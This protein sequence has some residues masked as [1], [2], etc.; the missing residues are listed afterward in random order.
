MGLINQKGDAQVLERRVFLKLLQHVGE[1]LLR[2]DDDRFAIL[3]EARQVVGF[4]GDAHHVFQVGE[5]RDVLPNIRVERF[6]VGEDERNVHQFFV[7]ARVV[8]AVQAVRQPADR[9]RLAA[10]GR[11]VGEILFADVALV[12]E[13]R[14]D[15]L[16][17]FP[18]Q[19]ALMVA[20]EQGEG[21]ALLYITLRL[22]FGHADQEER[23][24]LQQLLLG[25]NFA[26]QKLDRVFVRVPATCWSAPCCASGNSPP[27]AGRWRPSRR[28]C[29]RQSTET[30]AEKSSSRGRLRRTAPRHHARSDWPRASTPAPR[31]AGR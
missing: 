4:L 27:G 25:Q 9:E 26:V 19:P 20:W 15:V 22:A 24:C 28:S 21:R 29:R 11:V 2:G 14:S 8:E 3:K 16:R 1:L 12:G 13:V 5:V 23:E 6:A 30:E 31:W 18:H 17:D 10:P 7:R